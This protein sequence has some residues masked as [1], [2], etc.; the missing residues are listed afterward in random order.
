MARQQ[1]TVHRPPEMLA[2]EGKGQTVTPDSGIP[3]TLAPL[4][5]GNWLPGVEN[6][7]TVVSLPEK[8]TASQDI[9]NEEPEGSNTAMKLLFSAGSHVTPP[10]RE[11]PHVTPP[12]VDVRG[13]DNC[14]MKE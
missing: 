1:C 8:R 2:N 5:L 3:H 7:A 9:G 6:D 4:K 10:N 12:L 14:K 11:G 13:N